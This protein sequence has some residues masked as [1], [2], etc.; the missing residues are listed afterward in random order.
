M[1]SVVI[2]LVE[3]TPTCKANVTHLEVALEP[4]DGLSRMDC[5]ERIRPLVHRRDVLHLAASQALQPFGVLASRIEGLWLL[6]DRAFDAA[7]SP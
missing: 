3:T 5:H 2:S 4:L 7:M 1:V 6:C